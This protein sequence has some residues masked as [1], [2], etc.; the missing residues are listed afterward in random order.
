MPSRRV[1][2]GASGRA[3]A[4]GTRG[5][6]GA[7]SSAGGRPARLRIQRPELELRSRRAQLDLGSG[8]RIAEA[9]A[10]VSDGTVDLDE[11]ELALSSGALTVQ[12]GSAA[13]RFGDPRPGAAVELHPTAA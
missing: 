2:L 1:W 13:E 4:I 5:C 10:R 8:P 11:G 7:Y 6:P 3:G 9:F 12:G